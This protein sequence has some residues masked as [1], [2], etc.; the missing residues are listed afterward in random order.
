MAEVELPEPCLV[1]LV[2]AAGVGKSTF[3]ARW[4]DP[5]EILSS[6][7]LRGL[8]SGDEGDQSAT[9]PAFAILHR[10]LDRRLAAGATTVIDATNVTAFARRA[11]VRRAAKH[12]RPAVAVVLDL[13]ARLVRSRNATRAG[14]I[15]PEGA[16]RAQ[17]RDLARGLRHGE[18]EREGFEAVYH[19]RSPGDVDGLSMRRRALGRS[20]R[21]G[22]DQPD[23]SGRERDPNPMEAADPLPEHE[24][25][26]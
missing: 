23:R 16:V 26:Q 9:R 8:V 6:D 4:F 22:G 20:G 14:R 1:V 13:D 11:L 17:M 25:R 2:G 19:L 12:G 5:S 18:L 7:A 24:R 10:E 3:A 21:R 15:V